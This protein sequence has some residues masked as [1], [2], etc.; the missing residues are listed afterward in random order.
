MLGW[1][2]I[3]VSFAV[4]YVVEPSKKFAIGQVRVSFLPYDTMCLHS[5]KVF[6]ILWSEPRGQTTREDIEKMTEKAKVRTEFGD[7]FYIS[8]RRYI[9]AR[10]DQ[11]H[12]ICV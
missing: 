10:E 9:V 5:E 12:S 4:G 11:G 2:E 6:K 7:V 8:F 1:C 3:N